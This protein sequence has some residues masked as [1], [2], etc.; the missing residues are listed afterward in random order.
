MAATDQTY[1]NQRALD[2]V[3]G[4]SC[5]LLLLTTVWMFV[6]DANRDFKA[7]QRPCRDI[8]TGMSEREMLV[9]LPD[10]ELVQAK[11]NVVT[12][13]HQEVEDTKKQV[14]GD[15]RSLNARRERQDGVYR[16]IK[17][18]YDSLTSYYNIAIEHW[19]AEPPGPRKDS[20]RKEV[21]RLGG[22]LK[23]LERRLEDARR[24]LDEVVRELQEKV[25][26]PLEGP[27]KKL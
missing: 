18:E 3:F 20:L 4:A 5:G 8:E 16:G 17:A 10:P 9:K 7:V 26:R 27:Q 24:Q 21:D 13:A 25:D 6:Q 23:D 12:K 2:I 14:A 19:G 15:E 11:R 1:R 22:Q